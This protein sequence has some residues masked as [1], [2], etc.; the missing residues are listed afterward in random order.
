MSDAARSGSTCRSTS[1]L[2]NDFFTQLVIVAKDVAAR[3]RLRAKLERV[4]A[5]DFPGVVARICPAGARAA[6]GLAGAVSRERAG[7]G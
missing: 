6:G 4:L 3:E 2:A 1:Q 5:E 7:H